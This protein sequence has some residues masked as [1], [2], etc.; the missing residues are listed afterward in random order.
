[1][2]KTLRHVYPEIIYKVS[3]TFFFSRMGTV[4]SETV[5]RRIGLALR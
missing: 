5:P 4:D 1:M 3:L 2:H